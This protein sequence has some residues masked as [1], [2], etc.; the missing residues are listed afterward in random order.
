MTDS[1]KK[2]NV[3]FLKLSFEVIETL[4]K[5]PV[6]E[7]VFGEKISN[8]IYKIHNSPFFAFEFSYLD[9]VITE[10]NSKYPHPLIKSKKEESGH[11]TYRI[12]TNFDTNSIEFNH[13]WVNLEKAGCSYESDNR[14]LSVD[15]PKHCDINKIYNFLTEGENSNIWEFEEAHVSKHHRLNISEL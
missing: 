15:I 11:S 10:N 12:L 9:I 14:L 1:I 8:N 5:T 6:N 2:A 7:V 13:Y 4:Y 3:N